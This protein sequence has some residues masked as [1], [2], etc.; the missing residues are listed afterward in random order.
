MTPP[1]ERQKLLGVQYLRAVAALMVAY[2]HLGGQ[3]PHYSRFLVFGRLQMGVDI[4][5]VISGFIMF[6]TSH[7]SRPGEFAVRRIIRIVP[8]Y[9]LL[10]IALAA[11]AL[12]GPQLFRS[13]VLSSAYLVK[14][15]LFI[16]YA[17]PGQDGNLF[18]LLVPGWTLNFEMFFYLVFTVV[19]FA[20]LR[21]RLALSLVVF[22][23]VFVVGT[24]AELPATRSVFAFYGNPRLFEFWAGMLIGHFYARRTLSIPRVACFAMI[25][26][27]LLVLATNYQDLAPFYRPMGENA[28]SYLVPSAAIVLGVVGLE[29]SGGVRYLKWPALLG[30]AS[31]SIYLGHIFL[32]GVARTLWAHTRID[33]VDPVHAIL[34]ALFG[35]AICLTGSVLIYWWLEKPMHEALKSVYKRCAVVASRR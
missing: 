4:F 9:W 21:Y 30:D 2:L 24:R 1:P 8:L 26:V 15:L 14:S 12:I 6:V 13:T 22:S 3:M 27:G 11:M 23:V 20:K 34:F 18:P 28:L 25:I 32:L 7:D 16:P 35:M 19:L 17:N 10:T 5:F 33:Q 29:Y 31:Y